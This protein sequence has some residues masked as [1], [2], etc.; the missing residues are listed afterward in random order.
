[1][2]KKRGKHIT[3]PKFVEDRIKE[4]R[5][6]SF[7]DAECAT[8]DINAPRALIQCEGHGQLVGIHWMLTQPLYAAAP[9]MLKALERLATGREAKPLSIAR[10]AIAKAK[11]EADHE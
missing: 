6:D 4:I 9:D 5:K 10:A 2:K 3:R 7:Q 11:R 1:M 8:I